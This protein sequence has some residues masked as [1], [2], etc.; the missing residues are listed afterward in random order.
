MS[1]ISKDGLLSNVFEVTIQKQ[2]IS[3]AMYKLLEKIEFKEVE[4]LY[5]ANGT[6][7]TNYIEF[8]N[9]FI[10]NSVSSQVTYNFYDNVDCKLCFLRN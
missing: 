4:G 3:T 9:T 6:Y 2:E 5:L 7:K 8:M 1:L 10:K